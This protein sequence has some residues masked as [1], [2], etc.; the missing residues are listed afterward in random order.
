MIEI[1]E[2]IIRKLDKY[3]EPIFKKTEEKMDDKILSRLNDQSLSI[4]FWI[5]NVLSKVFLIYIIMGCPISLYIFGANV[6]Y[7]NSNPH[8]SY[9]GWLAL[10]TD[11]ILP[12]LLS[13]IPYI[14]MRISFMS[15]EKTVHQMP[16]QKSIF[17][18]TGFFLIASRIQSLINIV[19]AIIHVIE[20]AILN[21]PLM[22]LN[23]LTPFVNSIITTLY[24]LIAI[25]YIKAS[26]SMKTKQVDTL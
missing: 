8:I 22:L 10:I 3:I 18:A 23:L 12:I 17:F 15:L 20:E 24:I 5:T 2:G 13:F 11:L 9:Y 4:A 19:E 1:L 25:T 7:G 16:D 26:D 6:Y 21:S 14:I